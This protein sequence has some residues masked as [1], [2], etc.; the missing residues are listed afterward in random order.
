MD[1]HPHGDLPVCVATVLCDQV[2]EDVRSRNKSA[3]G[4]FNAIQTAQLPATHPRMY[5]MVSVT[6]VAGT[7]E[8][9][10]VLRSPSGKSV[11]NLEGKIEHGEPLATYDLVIELL[12]I[13]I[14]E[15]GVYFLDVMNGQNHLGGRRFSVVRQG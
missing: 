5:A 11:V 6:N 9:Q 3:I 13:P 2:I 12:G 4:I 7:V 14:E 10:M 8:I 1:A 15:E